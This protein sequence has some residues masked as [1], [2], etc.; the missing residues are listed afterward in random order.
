MKLQCI[1]GVRDEIYP[2]EK[3]KVFIS[4]GSIENAFI[5]ALNLILEAEKSENC[6]LWAKY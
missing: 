5:E 4:T 2:S 6:D 1:L 3:I